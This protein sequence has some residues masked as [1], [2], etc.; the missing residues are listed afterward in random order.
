MTVIFSPSWVSTWQAEI[1]IR[2]LQPERIG[3]STDAVKHLDFAGVGR[4]S[5]HFTM[6][7]RI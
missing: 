7:F 5:V 2:S 1:P 6:A 3:I 4:C